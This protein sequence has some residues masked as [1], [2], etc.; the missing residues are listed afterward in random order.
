MT[1]DNAPAA[2]TP[3]EGAPAG[4]A[5]GAAAADWTAGLDE[6]IR[7]LVEVKGWKSPADVIESYRNAEKL[8]G[9]DPG[10]ILRL[11]GAAA[12]DEEWA[13]VYDRLGRPAKPEDYALDGDHP[14]GEEAR[15]RFQADAHAMGLTPR[16]EARAWE[17]ELALFAEREQAAEAEI[18]QRQQQAVA[19]LRREWGEAFEGNLALAQQAVRRMG[20]QELLDELVDAGLADSP[21]LV[22]LFAEIGRMTGEDRGLGRTAD[23]FQALTP[24]GARAQ[25][26]Q[27]KA[28]S[29]FMLD[30]Y[31]KARPGHAAAKAKFDRLTDA[32]AA[33]GA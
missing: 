21:R 26:D 24:A 11:P 1:S 22:K 30:L 12:G 2:G 19:E 13:G 4:T 6:G 8:I 9:A 23:G 17:R 10:Q 27:L 15:R 3:A 28:D 20:G 25:L 16:Q 32:L 33:G 14:L 5:G 18:A 29:A 31:D 7:G